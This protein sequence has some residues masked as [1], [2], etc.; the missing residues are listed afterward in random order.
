MEQTNKKILDESIK[1]NDTTKAIEITGTVSDGVGF[2]PGVNIHIKGT[3]NNAIA[4]FN[5][6]FTINAKEGDILVCTFIGMRDHSITID[7]SKHYNI[8]MLDNNMVLGGVT[9]G[10][11]IQRKQRSFFGRLLHSVGN[12]FR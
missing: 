2:L 9:V 8:I 3:S 10:M 7:K 12:L 11:M 5:G 4:D 1:T 6:N